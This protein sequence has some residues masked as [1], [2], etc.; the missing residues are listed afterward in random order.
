ML[1]L[2]QIFYSPEKVFERVRERGTWLP[3]MVAM[4]LIGVLAGAVTMSMVSMSSIVRK[5]LE[6]DPRTV[7]RLG[8]DGIEK[9]ANNP[10]YKVSDMS[11]RSVFQSS[12]SLWRASSPAR[13]PITGA[14]TGLKG[15][16]A[17]PLTPGFLTIFS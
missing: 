9:V 6:A 13:C 7:E 10:A 11:L 1:G 16:L 2:L 17:R 3:P 8:P 14:Q 5:Q 4:V 15:C 12:L